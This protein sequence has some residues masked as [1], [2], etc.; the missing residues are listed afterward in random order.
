MV[1][2]LLIGDNNLTKFWPAQQFGRPNLKGS[3]LVTAT[4]LDTLD[5]ALTQFDERDQVIVSVLTSILIDEVNSLEVAGSSFNVYSEVVSRLAGMGPRSP[6]CQV[7]SFGLCGDS[8]C[9]SHTICF[10][11]CFYLLFVQVFLIWCNFFSSSLRLQRGAFYHVGTATRISPS[12][13]LWSSWY[14]GSPPKFIS[15]RSI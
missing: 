4:D 10:V 14:P 13:M 1:S 9:L 7:H 12:T 15:C 3:M 11:S 8:F 6:S 2:R 5:H